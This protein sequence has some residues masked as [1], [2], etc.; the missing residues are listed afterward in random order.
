MPHSTQI[1]TMIQGYSERAVT[2]S[3]AFGTVPDRRNS[4]P[5]VATTTPIPNIRYT[6]RFTACDGEP[7]H[8]VCS[9]DSG[10]GD[11][12][13]THSSWRA[14]ADGRANGM[15]GGE[16][17]QGGRHR[18]GCDTAGAIAPAVMVAPS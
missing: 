7:C 11:R 16:S 17:R 18:P 9:V 10:I 15:P 6:G 13:D 8:T 5:T 4:S 14:W 3:V 12:S 2:S 1:A